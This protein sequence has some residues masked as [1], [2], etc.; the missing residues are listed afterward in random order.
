MTSYGSLETEPRTLSY[1]QAKQHWR[2]LRARYA[3]MAV[4]FTDRVATIAD[5][6]KK[7]VVGFMVEALASDE[8]LACFVVVHDGRLGFDVK[9]LTLE[10]EILDVLSSKF[11]DEVIKS[12]YDWLIDAVQGS[13]LTWVRWAIGR[14][15]LEDPRKGMRA[16]F[17][18]VVYDFDAQSILG[19]S[20]HPSRSD[21]GKIVKVQL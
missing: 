19:I 10:P 12:A 15:E 14:L 3:A 7:A 9:N 2:A 11:E 20:T 1:E 6:K 13:S 17:D 21:A 8:N 18:H 4:R 16:V 5:P